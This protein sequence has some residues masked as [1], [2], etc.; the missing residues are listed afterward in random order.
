MKR[1]L[2]PGTGL[3]AIEKVVKAAR[4]EGTRKFGHS[5]KKSLEKAPEHI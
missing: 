2:T 1:A 4:K 5:Y 3:D